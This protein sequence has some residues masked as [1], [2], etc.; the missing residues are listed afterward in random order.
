MRLLLVAVF[1]VVGLAG[2]AENPTLVASGSGTVSRTW[3]TTPN[4][5]EVSI[6]NHHVLLGEVEIVGQRQPLKVAGDTNSPYNTSSI[7]PGQFVRSFYAPADPH[8]CPTCLDTP[9]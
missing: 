3:S 5:R 7:S 2:C 9:R 6:G 1:A 4:Q 8:A